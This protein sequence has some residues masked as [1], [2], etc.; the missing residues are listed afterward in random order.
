MFV[1]VLFV[2]HGLPETV[3]GGGEVLGGFFFFVVVFWFLVCEALGVEGV[4]VDDVEVDG[5]P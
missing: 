5:T 4:L 3:F 2:E 1:F